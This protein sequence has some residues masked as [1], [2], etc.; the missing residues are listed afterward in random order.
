M[1]SSSMDER[2]KW[3]GIRIK[4]DLKPASFPMKLGQK[5]E[6]MLEHQS[7]LQFWICHIPMLLLSIECNYAW[8][9]EANKIIDQ[10]NPYIGSI[11]YWFIQCRERESSVNEIQN[12]NQSIKSPSQHIKTLSA[13]YYHHQA[14]PTNLYYHASLKALQDLKLPCQ[15]H[16]S[17]IAEK[18]ER[19][20]KMKREE[21]LQCKGNKSTR[22]CQSVWH[23]L[24]FIFLK[25]DMLT[26]R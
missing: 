2:D 19:L 1:S 3:I 20:R 24:G 18:R 7:N 22:C 11:H 6:L 14:P 13:D 16:S 25:H 4:W 21:R 10:S 9:N 23:R 8:N 15:F 12:N 5:N 26:A 17:Y